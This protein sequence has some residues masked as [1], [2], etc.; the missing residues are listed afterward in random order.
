MPTNMSPRYLLYVNSRLVT[1]S[2]PSWKQDPA[3]DEARLV[4]VKTGKAERPPFIQRANYMPGR[5]WGGYTD[6]LQN[7]TIIKKEEGT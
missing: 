4:D 2:D 5:S 3:V 6:H 1:F 7:I